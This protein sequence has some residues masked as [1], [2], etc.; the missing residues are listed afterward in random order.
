M[1]KFISEGPSHMSS[2]SRFSI[3]L[4]R[5]IWRIRVDILGN[6]VVKLA[7]LSRPLFPAGVV[8]FAN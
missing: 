1:Y 4:F 8:R 2:S 7:L 5:E 3:A 6:P